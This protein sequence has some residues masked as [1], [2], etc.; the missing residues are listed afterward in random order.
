MSTGCELRGDSKQW[1]SKPEMSSTII[2][3]AT[4]VQSR[5]VLYTIYTETADKKK[6]FPRTRT[7]TCVFDKSGTAGERTTHCLTSTYHSLRCFPPNKQ[8][9]EHGNQHHSHEP[10]PS[11]ASQ[12]A[13]AAIH[14]S[15]CRLERFPAGKKHQQVNLSAGGS[16][17][18][19]CHG[20]WYGTSLKPARSLIAAFAKVLR[21][22]VRPQTKRRFLSNLRPLPVSWS[23]SPLRRSFPISITTARR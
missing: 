20:A 2:H 13:L 5:G 18:T 17:N 19:C 21:R 11:G 23:R 22:C 1:C 9:D 7:G 15:G 6:T 12:R 8:A 14:R 10:R 16:K 4:V 3:V